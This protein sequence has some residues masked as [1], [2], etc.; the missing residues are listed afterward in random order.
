MSPPGVVAVAESPWSKPVT[1]QQ[2]LFLSSVG[3]RLQMPMGGMILT[4]RHWALNGSSLS[5]GWAAR[6]QVE[7]AG[8]EKISVPADEADRCQAG[9]AEQRLLFNGSC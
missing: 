5:S 1:C 4:D 2:V 3:A 7:P 6:S 9:A 8:L